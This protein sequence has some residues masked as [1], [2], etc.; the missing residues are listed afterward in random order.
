VPLV[1]YVP[2]DV[3]VRYRFWRAETTVRTAP[4]ELP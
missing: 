2:A 3:E 4:A 1:V